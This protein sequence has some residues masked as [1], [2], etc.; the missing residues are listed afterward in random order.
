MLALVLQ[1]VQQALGQY[2]EEVETRAFPS[3]AFSPYKIAAEHRQAA[4]EAA[5]AE[6]FPAAA[7]VL[8]AA[9]AAETAQ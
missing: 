4:A 7:A 6:G 1:A 2:R 8:E 3:A 5:R 9:D